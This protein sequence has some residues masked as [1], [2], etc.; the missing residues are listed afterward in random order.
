MAE[1]RRKNGDADVAAAAGRSRSSARRQDEGGNG[2]QLTE[3]EER[4]TETGLRGDMV[5]DGVTTRAR[6]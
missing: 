3:D 4:R 2:G 1:P 6:T 5:S